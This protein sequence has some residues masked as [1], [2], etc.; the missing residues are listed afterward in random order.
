[1]GSEVKEA[2]D[3]SPH[4]LTQ[5]AL[6]VAHGLRYLHSLKYVHR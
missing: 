2:D 4:K 6:D 1:M 5:M 3:V